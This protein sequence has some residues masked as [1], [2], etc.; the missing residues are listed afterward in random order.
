MTDAEFNLWRY[1]AEWEWY[2]ICKHLADGDNG[3]LEA[4]R[5]K[6][7]FRWL[8]PPWPWIA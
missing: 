5:E 7:M 8:L 4:A 6:A 2:F 1:V 3:F